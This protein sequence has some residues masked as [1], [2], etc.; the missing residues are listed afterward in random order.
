MLETLLKVMLENKKGY[1]LFIVASLFILP[2]VGLIYVCNPD[3]FMQMDVAK[4]IILAATID[5]LMYI[6]CFFDTSIYFLLQEM[7]G[8][9]KTK[10]EEIVVTPL[11]VSS[12]ILIRGIIVKVLNEKADIKMFLFKSGILGTILFVIFLVLFCFIMC[13]NKIKNLI[14]NKNEKNKSTKKEIN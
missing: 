14:K 3:K 8:K 7:K 10:V 2:G 1:F 9:R 4:I 12:F 5:L 13:F 11:M 6:P